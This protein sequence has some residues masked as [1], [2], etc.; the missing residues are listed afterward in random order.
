VVA[1][2]RTLSYTYTCIC[3]CDRSGFPEAIIPDIESWGLMD[4]D[5]DLRIQQMRIHDQKSMFAEMQ[6]PSFP[7]WNPL[8]G[9]AST[10]GILHG[11]SRRT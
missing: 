9:V 2:A 1:E 11:T 10:Y 4:G 7:F 6:G 3:T 8:E 5:S